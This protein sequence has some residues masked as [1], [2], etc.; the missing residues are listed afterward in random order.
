LILGIDPVVPDYGRSDDPEFTFTG[1]DPRCILVSLNDNRM[2]IL[3][4][5]V[6]GER[7]AANGS[8]ACPWARQDTKAP[9]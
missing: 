8:H 2:G 3:S 6:S 9:A 4:T 7:L 1:P 5:E